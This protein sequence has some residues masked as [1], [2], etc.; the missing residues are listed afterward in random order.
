MECPRDQRRN[1]CNTEKDQHRL[2]FDAEERPEP[3]GIEVPKANQ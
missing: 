2:E 3:T 1:S